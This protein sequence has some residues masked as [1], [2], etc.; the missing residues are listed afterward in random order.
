MDFQFKIQDPS[1]PNTTYILEEIIRLIQKGDL[2]RWRGIYSWT[3]GKTLSKVFIEDPDVNTFLKS[4]NVDL[5]I[6]LDAI[7]TDYALTELLKLNADYAGFSPKVFHNDICDLFHPKISHFEFE[8]G[9]HILL[10]G[11]GN[12]TLT[13]LQTNIE[14]YTITSGTLDEISSLSVWED[15][16]AFHSERIRAIDEDAIEKAKKNRIRFARKKK[17]VEA[18]IDAE[19]EVEAQAVQ[20]EVEEI[21][22]TPVAAR[23]GDKS[24]ILISQVPAAGGR[25]RQ[26][27]YNAAV[28]EQFFQA[29]A[30]SH[31]RIFLKEVRLDGSLGPDEVRPVVYSNSNKNYK[32]EVSSHLESNYPKDGKPI[33]VLREVGVRNFLYML[34]MP[35]EQP[36]NSL[37]S[38]LNENES[39]GKGVKRVITDSVHLRDIWQDCPLVD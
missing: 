23:L 16:L 11:S 33:I 29:Q 15:F 24:R 28:I 13:G 8:S 38:F 31:Q 5:V 17:I 3:T 37:I 2:K 14:A 12:F 22:D 35:D 9:E 18:E 1:N 21:I 30:N 19:E 36:Y 25:W 6:G 10:V 26:I 4:G 20:E 7:T 32:I 34:I 39:L 27:H